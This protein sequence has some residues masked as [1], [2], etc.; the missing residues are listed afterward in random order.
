MRVTVTNS[1]T[2]QMTVTVVAALRGHKLHD[3]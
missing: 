3:L 1:I 2:T